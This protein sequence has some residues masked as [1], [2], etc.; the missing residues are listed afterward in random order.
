MTNK[1]IFQAAL[2]KNLIKRNVSPPKETAEVLINHF[3][4]GDLIWTKSQ[5]IKEVCAEL[6]VKY[7][8]EEIQQFLSK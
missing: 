2:E 3:I 6:G 1:Q 4:D 5:G 8:Y 7:D